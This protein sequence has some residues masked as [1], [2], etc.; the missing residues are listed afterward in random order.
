MQRYTLLFITVNA[1][2][3]SGCFSAHHQKLKNCTH[4]LKYVEH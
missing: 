2:R 1:L 3:I 4:S